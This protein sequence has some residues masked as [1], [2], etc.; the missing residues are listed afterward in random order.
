MTRSAGDSCVDTSNALSSVST[1]LS[2]LRS[3]PRVSSTPAA[4]TEG[5][6]S[7]RHSSRSAARCEM[8]SQRISTFSRMTASACLRTP[9]AT[10]RV[11]PSSARIAGFEGAM[12]EIAAIRTSALESVSIIRRSSAV[13]ASSGWA[14][15]CRR[16]SARSAHA[17]TTGTLSRQ[18]R[19]IRSSS[20]LKS[21]SETSASSGMA[22]ITRPTSWETR[23]RTALSLASDKPRR[24]IQIV[25][26]SSSCSAA[27]SSSASVK[28]LT[29]NSTA[30]SATGSRLKTGKMHAT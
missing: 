13:M 9:S 5:A 8:V 7:D 12:V 26:I 30:R 18:R 20:A 21:S 22:F 6:R 3:Q 27:F 11:R 2:A 23:K 1:C 14:G 24:A 25:P 19:S 29:T 17:R 10:S 16:K 28:Y 4:R 15:S